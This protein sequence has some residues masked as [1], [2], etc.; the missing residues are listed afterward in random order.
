MPRK[1]SIERGELSPANEKYCQARAD[2]MSQR[3]AYQ[4]SRPDSKASPEA[5]D[6]IA[7]RIESDD[8]IALRI[9]ELKRRAAAGLILTRDEI[10]ADLATMASDTSR[11]DGI[12]L[13]AYDQL[14]RIVGAYEDRQNV[15]ISGA[16]LT[17]KDKADAI[18][19]F[20]SGMTDNGN[21]E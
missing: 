13:K 10:A 18:R 7:C 3:K 2:G 19:D 6:V 20:L 15:T 11:S 5:A 9:E 16:I 21:A 17:G 8:K 4:A 12:R 1:K 14:S